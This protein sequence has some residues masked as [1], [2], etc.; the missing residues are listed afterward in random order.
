MERQ[1]ELAPPSPHYPQFLQQLAVMWWRPCTTLLGHALPTTWLSV[2]HGISIYL[3]MERNAIPDQEVRLLNQPLPRPSLSSYHQ[4]RAMRKEPNLFSIQISLCCTNSVFHS[5]TASSG[6]TRWLL[7][8]CQPH[9]STLFFLQP[10]VSWLI[11]KQ[12]LLSSSQRAALTHHH[13]S[14]WKEIWFYAQ[15]NQGLYWRQW[16]L[17][18]ASYC[19]G[20]KIL[21]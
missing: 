13:P 16:Y 18:R 5:L 8:S 11:S 21:Y 19:L 15:G 10:F 17:Q 20:K 2:G 12:G 7:S 9:V 14:F 1:Q 6:T 4:V 3:V